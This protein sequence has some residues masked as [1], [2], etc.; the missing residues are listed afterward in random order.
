MIV[1]GGMC[2]C[3]NDA[4]KKSHT[5]LGYAIYKTKNRPDAGLSSVIYYE[6]FIEYN[7]EGFEI[8]HL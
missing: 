3:G 8:C 4:G 1:V 7:Q 2:F 6:F 5:T